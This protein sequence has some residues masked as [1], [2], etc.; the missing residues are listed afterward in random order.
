M[1]HINLSSALLII[2]VALTGMNCFSQ[3]ESHKVI[4]LYKGAAPGSEDWNWKESEIVKK[5]DTSIY[6]VTVPTL[7]VFEADK[8]IANGTAVVVCPGGGFHSLAT[9][10]EGIEIAKW[11]NSKGI[12]AFVLKYR[13]A[14]CLTDNPTREMLSK[15]I[16]TERFNQALEPVI[17]MSIADGRTAVAYVRSHASEWGLKRIGIMGFSAGGGVA[18][19]VAFTYNAQSRPDFVAPIYPFVGNI[20]NSA[21]PADAP[22][23]FITVTSDDSFG[24]NRSCTTLYDKWLDAKMSMELHIYRKGKHGFALSKQNIP[25]DTWTDRFCDWLNSL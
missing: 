9:H 11:L 4:R 7:T 2:F 6:N 5:A 25:T 20:A 21:V 14:H 22:P 17:T 13:L 12:T 18:I 23:M 1:K 19:G 15:G 10:G 16:G 24:F 3:S 8:S